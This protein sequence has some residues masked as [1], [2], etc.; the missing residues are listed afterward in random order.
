[1]NAKQKRNSAIFI[2]SFLV[3]KFILN[4]IQGNWSIIN[5]FKEEWAS[6]LGMILSYFLIVYLNNKRRNK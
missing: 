5:L 3:T 4:G 1:M 2:L 6:L